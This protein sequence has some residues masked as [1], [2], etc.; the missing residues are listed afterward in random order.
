MKANQFSVHI[1]IL[2]KMP[3]FSIKIARI[4]GVHSLFVQ[5]VRSY[6]KQPQIKKSLLLAVMTKKLDNL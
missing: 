6:S 4:M 5:Q 3:G 1:K 2:A